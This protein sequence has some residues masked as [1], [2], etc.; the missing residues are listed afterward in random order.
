[1][2]EVRGDVGKGEVRKEMWG[3][4]LGLH[5][6]TNFPTPPPFLY[7]HPFPICQHTSSPHTLSHTPLHSPHTGTLYHTSPLPSHLS[8]SPP[9]PLDI[10]LHLPPHPNTLP[11]TFPNSL[12][13]VAKLPCDDVTLINLIG[14]A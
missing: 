10:S 9:T 13:Y 3:S 4:L 8:L 11:H 2:G 5:T 6:L 1:M 7:P 12:N 14:K